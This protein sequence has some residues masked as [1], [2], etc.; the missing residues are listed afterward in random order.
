VIL[1]GV[2]A[3]IA[4]SLGFGMLDVDRL[5]NQI[6]EKILDLGYQN[7]EKAQAKLD[8]KLNEIINLVFDQRVEAVS[9]KISKAISL[10]ENLLEQQE[11]AHKETVEQRQAEKSWISHQ[12][13]ELEQLQKNIEAILPS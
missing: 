5:K 9:G 11:K 4:G 2:A 10:Y 12:R 1:A 8:S 6:K 7:F 3:T 13:H